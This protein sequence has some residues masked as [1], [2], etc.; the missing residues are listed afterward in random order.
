MNWPW[1]AYNDVNAIHARH[2]RQT[3]RTPQTFI[4]DKDGKIVYHHREMR[5]SD[6]MKLFAKLESI[7]WKVAFGHWLLCWLFTV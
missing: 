6:E 7:E 4:L 1:E 3:Q 2:A 5:F